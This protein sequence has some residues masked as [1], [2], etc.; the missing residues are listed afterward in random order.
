MRRTLPR[1]HRPRAVA[2]LAPAVAAIAVFALAAPAHA[3]PRPGYVT[4]PAATV[5]TLTGTG[6]GGETVGSIN[7]FPGPTVPFGMVQFSPDNPNTGQGYYY[8]NSTLRGFGLDHAS[9]GCGALGDFPVLPTTTSMAASAKPWTKTESYSHDGEVGTPGY[10]QLTSTDAA[11]ANIT[12]RLTATTRTGVATFT[13]PAGTTPSVTF[14]SGVSNSGG[15]RAGAIDVNPNTGI[16]T[17]WTKS[18]N[19]CGKN[20]S[21]TA[22]FAATVDAGIA[23]YGAWD[24]S[25]GTVHVGDGSH[26]AA[27]SNAR[28]GGYLSFAP[29]T[30]TVHLKIAMSYVSTD[31]AILNM[32]TEVPTP[33]AAAHGTHPYG[34]WPAAFD[35]V[36]GDAHD[37][38][39]A[40]LSTV[41][42]SRTATAERTSTFYHSL[43]RSLLHPNTF[44]DVNG[45]YLGFEATPK[46][47]N[48]SEHPGS[49][50]RARHQYAYY[51]DWDTY[52]T[53]T[54]LQ[55]LLFPDRAADMAQSLV[56]DAEQSGSYPRWAFA[57]AGTNQMSGDSP[58]ALIAQT[59]TF[60]ARGFDVPTALDYMV[61]G[62]VGRNAGRNTGGT[63]DQAVERFGATVYNQRHYAPQ[64][65]Q[66]QTDHAVTGASI[67]E[68]YSVDDF[69][70]GRLAGSLGRHDLAAEFQDRSNY[71]QNLFNPATRYV[72][73]RDGSGA[74]PAGDGYTIPDDF[75][76]RGH[77]TGFGSVG[78]D[79]GNAEQYLWLVPQNVGG[80]VTALGGDEIVGRRLDAF[81][82]HGMNVGPN[83]PYMWAGNEPD[84][85]VPWYY[86][87]LGQPWRTSEVV[88]EIRT[89]LFGAEPNY[90]EP[91][92]DDLG[93]QS[94]W[95][96]WAALGLFPATPGTD[97][98]TVNAPAFDAARLHLAAG[99]TLDVTAAGADE[100]RRYVAGL[101]VDRHPGTA[102]YLHL[103]SLAR[104]ATVD[105]TLAG[106]PSHTWGTRA[107]DAPPS[108]GRGSA[109]FAVHA[110]PDNPAVEPGGS[111]A[112]TVAAQ[113]FQHTSA[114]VRLTAST[115]VAGLT[116][117]PSAA[118]H[119][120]KTGAG[121]ARL[122]VHAAASV[123]D[124]YY[125]VRVT[126]RAGAASI[127]TESTVRVARGGGLLAAASLVGTSP[128][129]AVDGNFDGGGNSYARDQLAS[130]GLAPGAT[131][132]LAN[133]TTLT[134]P[135]AP[136]GE[137][138]T[139]APAGQR[140]TLGTPASRISFVG[141]GIN[142]G[143]QN[144][145]TVELS[146]GTT[147][148]ADLSFGDWVLP[149]NRGSKDD[150]TLEPV[151]GN[152]VVAWTPV[153]NASSSDPGAYVFATRPYV[154]PAGTHVVSVTLPTSDKVRVF[155]IAQG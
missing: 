154:A 32:N 110:G 8:A 40:A 63:N 27:V 21:Y 17:G 10:Y 64:V 146:D 54:P 24:E 51:S 81:M 12:S 125:P 85:G 65:K 134:W 138:E 120:D 84:F 152:S 117:T 115:S 3:A 113:R 133:G 29:G 147:A 4:D 137:P 47:H 77:I 18:G 56:N 144:T 98:L 7:N 30:R 116:V 45:Q 108:Y 38:W 87:H 31:N 99:R 79:E 149:S 101:R 14:R 145:A 119:L 42:V 22:Y 130:A 92:N 25:S 9:Q 73:P 114:R 23:G 127:R 95:Y 67:T 46:V 111:V 100:G 106:R 118:I 58:A 89:T 91:G 96:V 135:S 83:Q 16:V 15:T 112:L 142:G 76:Y 57:N 13:F 37:A 75:G 123:P 151:Y 78:Y 97:V 88:D 128:R 140:I 39:R 19:F 26:D 43:Y 155:T 80:L 68:E 41:Q 122:T 2:V 126:A 55:S 148:R 86:N 129:D 82:S 1:R 74:F 66:F 141:A 90:A 71:W 6:T 131:T 53:L 107:A 102:T 124:G 109:P 61:R 69:A 136:V 35:G 105:F 48:V 11:G 50:G 36:R 121:T 20:N 132:T 52:R 33:S 60:G 70:I 94:S 59:Y 93:A 153:R 143:G 150:G 34:S 139:V 104:A 44:D 28:A 103:D 72:S 49:G 62:A 5:N